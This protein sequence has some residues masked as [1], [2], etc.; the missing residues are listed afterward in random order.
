LKEFY[1]FVSCGFIV[2]GT[3]GRETVV[4]EKTDVVG[5]GGNWYSLR[6]RRD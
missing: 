2:R 3:S 4:S 1:N 6:R 5:S